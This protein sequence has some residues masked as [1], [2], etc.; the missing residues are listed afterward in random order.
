MFV[1][2]VFACERTYNV[3]LIR[4][5]THKV[6]Y[7]KM[8]VRIEFVARCLEKILLSEGPINHEEEM[9][10]EAEYKDK[11]LE[12]MEE[13]KSIILHLLSQLKLGMD[14]TKVNF[15]QSPLSDIKK[16]NI[17]TENMTHLLLVQKKTNKRSHNSQ[18][19]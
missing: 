9:E 2:Q 17:Q 5:E 3:F 12:G 4:Y 16:W 7:R 13:H 8:I 18:R 11:D 14:L 1:V 15:T 19:F 6:S 10:D